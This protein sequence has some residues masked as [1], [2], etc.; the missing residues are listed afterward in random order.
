[1]KTAEQVRLR[2]ERTRF[3]QEF[4]RVLGLTPKRRGRAVA[5]LTHAARSKRPT[6]T[7]NVLSGVRNFSPQTVSWIKQYVRSRRRAKGVLFYDCLMH[8]DADARGPARTKGG[9]S[10]PPVHSRPRRVIIGVN[11]CKKNRF[12]VICSFHGR[13]RVQLMEV[14]SVQIRLL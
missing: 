3:L 2:R 4:A 8:P 10:V 7:E 6:T 11:G 5:H 9:F 14:T 13:K 12:A 1:M